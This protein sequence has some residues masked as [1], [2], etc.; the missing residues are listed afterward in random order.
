MSGRLGALLLAA[1][2][3]TAVVT[4]APPGR[5]AAA[6]DD[7]SDEAARRTARRHFKKGEKLFALGRFEEALVEYEAA[8]EAYPLPEFLF[9]IGQCHRNLKRWDEAIFSFKKYLRLKPNAENREAVEKLIAEL[10]EERERERERQGRGR[11][12]LQPIPDGKE[13]QRRTVVRSSPIYARWWFWAGI[14]LVGGAVT[15][16]ALT[17]GDDGP[18]GSDLGNIDFPR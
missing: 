7:D 13:P 6:D 15:T 14:A 5:P 17:Q 9:N 2:V 8:F 18:P 16:Y 12:R 11:Q 4:T 1:L 10:E 3:G